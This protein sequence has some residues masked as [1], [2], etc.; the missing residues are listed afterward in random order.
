MS[1]RPAHPDPSAFPSGA[2]LPAAEAA[3]RR[4]DVVV[5]GAGP[6]G[7][8]LAA[9]LASRGRAVLLVERHRH[10]RDKTC[11][12]GLIADA[13]RALE[14]LGLL[15]EVRRLGHRARTVSVYSPRRIHV[16]VPGDF[17]TLRRRELDA[18]LLR[19]ALERG[20]RIVVGAVEGVRATGAAG[21]EGAAVVL[22]GGASTIEARYAA[23]A[24]GADVSLAGGYAPDRHPSAIAVRRYVSSPVE[25]DDLV[26]SFDRSIVPGYGWIFPMGGGVHNVGC[27][28]FYAEG[29]NPGV[30]LRAMY[31][32]FVREFPL[33]RRLVAEAADQTPLEGA[34]LRCGLDGDPVRPGSPVVAVGET[35][36]TTFPFTGEGVGKAMETGEA[37][38]AALDAALAAADP[39]RLAALADAVRADLKPKYRGYEVAQRWLSAAWLCD[40]VAA[41]VRASA[42]LQRRV[43]GILNE[44]ADPREVFSLR[45]L[46]GAALGG[47]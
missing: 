10:P 45:G 12:D 32:A 20:A 4:W 29:G 5:V 30:N 8:T 21:T 36:G 23:I 19:T 46:V 40:L 17:V 34:R 1:D 37:A 22:R 44:T 6:A 18:L 15:E 26:V 2:E 16:P 9:H 13:L 47:R 31:D 41:R 39:A 3:A 42:A 35:I 7:S 38:A 25:I 43:E 11:G 28:V 27:G 14:R 33:A 24:T